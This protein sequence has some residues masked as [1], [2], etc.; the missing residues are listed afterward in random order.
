[1]PDGKQNPGGINISWV[2]HEGPDPELTAQ[3]SAIWVG[4]VTEDIAFTVGSILRQTLTF[5]RPPQ[6]YTRDFIAA[7]ID[8]NAVLMDPENSVC[9]IMAQRVGELLNQRSSEVDHL[10]HTT[11]L[12]GI[13]DAYTNP[14]RPR[15]LRR[16]VNAVSIQEIPANKTLFAA[17]HHSMDHFEGEVAVEKAYGVQERVPA[18]SNDP[19]ALEIA[20]FLYAICK[21][22]RKVEKE[23][24]GLKPS[25]LKNKVGVPDSSDYYGLTEIAIRLRAILD[26]CFVHIGADRQKRYDTIIAKIILGK[27]KDIPELQ[28]LYDVFK[29]KKFGA[30]YV[31]PEKNRYAEIRNERET[32]GNFFTRGSLIMMVVCAGFLLVNK[33]SEPGDQEV[34]VVDAQP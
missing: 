32:I 8:T 24:I 30:A 25:H 2:N 16:G 3:N 10:V 14:N 6:L 27:L 1:M 28:P 5:S 11:T 7:C 9:I 18:L 22:N 19:S 29:G 31:D 12:M 15:N 13:V 4:P 33:C 20:Q 21:I 34:D 23:F 26:G 17:L